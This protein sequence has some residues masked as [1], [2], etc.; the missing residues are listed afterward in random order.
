MFY[1]SGSN[2]VSPS[3]PIYA[4][5]LRERIVQLTTYHGWRVRGRAVVKNSTSSDS[6]EVIVQSVNS[7]SS[8]R[9]SAAP[10]HVEFFRQVPNNGNGNL[11]PAAR[12]WW[13]SSAAAAAD[14]RS[15][16]DAV[17]AGPAVTEIPG[18]FAKRRLS[19]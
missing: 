8:E 7:A 13:L 4:P 1:P 11:R 6:G 19:V 16:A 3:N 2:D 17:E 14:A 18:I 12:W 9:K 10:C 5:A 15:D